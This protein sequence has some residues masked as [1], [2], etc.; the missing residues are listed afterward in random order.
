MLGE[1]GGVAFDGPQDS[2]QTTVHTHCSSG[3]ALPSTGTN[4]LARAFFD[5]PL[6]ARL[7]RVNSV[8]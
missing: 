2:G 5:A 6:V 3:C 1:A 7:G 8:M 4:G